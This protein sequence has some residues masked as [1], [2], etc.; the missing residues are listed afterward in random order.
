[1]KRSEI[2]AL[3]KRALALASA[4]CLHFG[5]VYGLA[6]KK[7]SIRAQR[8]RWGSCSKSGNLSFNYK[9]AVL[10]RHIADYIIAHEVCHLAEM[11]HGKRF[12]DLVGKT[13]PLHKTTRAEL[14]LVVVVYD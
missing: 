11:N 12:W 13:I 8:S 1:V 4:R 5:K 3:K 7:I 2:P 9:I 14:R 6:F 10:P